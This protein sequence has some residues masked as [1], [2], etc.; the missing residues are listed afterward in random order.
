[1]QSL[2]WKPASFTSGGGDFS[3]FTVNVKVVVTVK[4]WALLLVT[5][6]LVHRGGGGGG[7][8]FVGDISK[9]RDGL[10][11]RFS[12]KGNKFLKTGSLT[13]T[14]NWNFETKRDKFSSMNVGGKDILKHL[15][16]VFVI[17]DVVVEIKLSVFG[18]VGL[19]LRMPIIWDWLVS[20]GND[21][22]LSGV[23][24]IPAKKCPA[25]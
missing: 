14:K 13:R 8:L 1:M 15:P 2:T 16:N 19:G 7:V 6:G 4:F 11:E 23:T 3:L 21:E 12:T 25:K 17:V 18:G 20:T 10:S 24:G 9:F 22:G 5:V